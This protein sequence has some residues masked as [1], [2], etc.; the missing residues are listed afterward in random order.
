MALGI[1]KP[2]T[3]RF[4]QARKDRKELIVIEYPIINI[5]LSSFSSAEAL[6]YKPYSR[7]L[8]SAGI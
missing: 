6:N 1:L 2:L 7:L 8:C 4:A 5:Q 3:A